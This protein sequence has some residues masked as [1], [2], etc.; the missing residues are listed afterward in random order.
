[1]QSVRMRAVARHRKPTS[2]RSG[3]EALG[4]G[5]RVSP[6]RSTSRSP[7]R[8]PRDAST[9]A[10]CAVVSMPPS[11]VTHQRRPGDWALRRHCQTHLASDGALADATLAAQN[12]HNLLYGGQAPGRRLRAGAVVHLSPPAQLSPLTT[13]TLPTAKGSARAPDRAGR[14]EPAAASRS[15]GPHRI[16]G[17]ARL[18]SRQQNAPG[19]AYTSSNTEAGR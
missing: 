4:H 16:I 15:N 3:K 12:Q 7:T 1:M 19:P 17:I 14:T 10:T 2:S 11:R 5:Q 9:D 13:S 6:Q 18:R 8:F